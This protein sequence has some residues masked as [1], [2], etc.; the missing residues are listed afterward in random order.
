MP[1]SVMLENAHKIIDQIPQ[2]KMVYVL[3]FLESAKG[4]FAQPAEDDQAKRDA[5]F[6]K[7]KQFQ[8]IISAD[9]DFEQEKQNYL[10]EKYGLTK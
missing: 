6:E 10:D 9:D 7:L 2:D 1:Y 5:A 4:L 8:G 3:Q